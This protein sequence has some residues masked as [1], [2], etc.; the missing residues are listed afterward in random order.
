MLVE[1]SGSLAH[2]VGPVTKPA[3]DHLLRLNVPAD[4]GTIP[5]AVRGHKGVLQDV[6]FGSPFP[7]R[8]CRDLLVCLIGEAA[9]PQRRDAH[10]SAETGVAGLTARAPRGAKSR[11]GRGLHAD[12][13]RV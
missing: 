5:G 9:V 8:G 12:I 1:T 7:G 11:G 3:H 6:L 2:A 13:C 4:Q 10:L